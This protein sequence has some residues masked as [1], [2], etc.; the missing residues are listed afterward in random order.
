MK[1]LKKHWKWAP[2]AAIVVLA[3]VLFAVMRKFG[4]R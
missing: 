1:T 3:L 2:V 4:R